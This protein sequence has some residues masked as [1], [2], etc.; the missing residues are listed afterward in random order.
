MLRTRHLLAT[1]YYTWTRLQV[2]YPG[3]KD[4]TPT[5]NSRSIF[6]GTNRSTPGGCCFL[7]VM[8]IS[9]F[10][11]SSRLGMTGGKAGA[12]LFSG[13]PPLMELVLSKLKAFE[14]LLMQLFSPHKAS[15]RWSQLSRPSLRV[16]RIRG[17]M[18]T[19]R[20]WII[21]ARE[22]V[23]PFNA[24]YAIPGS[25]NCATFPTKFIYTSQGWHHVL[26]FSWKIQVLGVVG[27][28]NC[29]E[30]FCI[31]VILCGAYDVITATCEPASATPG[32]L[33]ET[34]APKT[35]PV[36]TRPVQSRPI[37]TRRVNLNPPA[38]LPNKPSLRRGQ[39]R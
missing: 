35:P 4:R 11:F 1:C 9:S 28:S 2:N 6:R 31:W 15:S 16:S 13:P 8:L 37:H 10:A 14:L 17:A 24:L 12:T 26:A 21:S 33:T 38:G 39:Q 32:M 30:L 25:S 19:V 29:W 34:I 3:K 20:S 7:Q 27:S 5:Q 36:H 18:L 22:G 23:G